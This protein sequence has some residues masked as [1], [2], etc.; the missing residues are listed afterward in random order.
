[1][2]MCR[3]GHPPPAPRSCPSKKRGCRPLAGSN[4][5]AKD[6]YTLPLAVRI[7]SGHRG[8]S[9]PVWRRRSRPRRQLCVPEGQGPAEAGAVGIRRLAWRRP[10]QGPRSGMHEPARARRPRCTGG[11]P[12]AGPGSSVRRTCP[13]AIRFHARAPRR[14]TARVRNGASSTR[15]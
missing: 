6:P 13:S 10:P 2:M 7:A 5:S 12:G 8:R 9:H 15:A 4:R 1:V 14:I 11:F 3:N